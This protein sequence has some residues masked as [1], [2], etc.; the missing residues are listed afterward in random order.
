MFD[1]LAFHPSGAPGVYIVSLSQCIIKI[2][3]LSFNIAYNHPRHSR[4]SQSIFI[5][6]ITCHHYQN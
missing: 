4:L 6:L 3:H 5:T 1:I 2:H